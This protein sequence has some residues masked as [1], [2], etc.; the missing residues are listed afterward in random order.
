MDGV[1][2]VL[3]HHCWHTVFF[4]QSRT[5]LI[6]MVDSNRVVEYWEWVKSNGNE[7]PVDQCVSDKLNA[8]DGCA[9]STGRACIVRSSAFMFTCSF[10]NST[11]YTSLPTAIKGTGTEGQIAL[12]AILQ[13]PF[14]WSWIFSASANRNN[15]SIIVISWVQKTH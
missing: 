12:S 10:I 4:Y 2:T 15:L 5:W 14:Y 13:S 9:A 8:P 3:K 11:V 6:V 1:T 7:M